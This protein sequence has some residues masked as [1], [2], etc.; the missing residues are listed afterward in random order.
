M[1]NDILDKKKEKQKEETTTEY[2]KL[3]KEKL[4][5]K[6]PHKGV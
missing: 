4:K 1:F 5:Q 3:R 6:L 2:I